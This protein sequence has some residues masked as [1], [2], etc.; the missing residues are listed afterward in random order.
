MSWR[1]KRAHISRLI[2]TW[3]CGTLTLLCQ[4]CQRRRRR[5][6]LPIAATAGFAWQ[7]A[8]VRACVRARATTV[9]GWESG[10]LP[11]RDRRVTIPLSFV[12]VARGINVVMFLW[13]NSGCRGYYSPFAIMSQKRYV[14]VTIIITIT[15]LRNGHFII[16]SLL[17]KSY[18]ASP[19]GHFFFTLLNQSASVWLYSII[20]ASI[21]RSSVIFRFLFY[22][23]FRQVYGNDF[24]AHNHFAHIWC[25]NAHIHT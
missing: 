4:Q 3:Q 6:P 8:P 20:S 2:H 17:R 19:N 15:K 5:S 25:N 21:D 1:F 18:R 10:R 14:L 7:A 16:Y 22:H 12:C 11:F 9:D 24:I 13:N 23:Y